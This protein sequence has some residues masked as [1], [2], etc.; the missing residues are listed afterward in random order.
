MQKH[1]VAF[2]ALGSSFAPQLPTLK[3]CEVA[4]VTLQFSFGRSDSATFLSVSRLRAVSLFSVVRRAK[5]ETR[6]RPRAWL[7]VRDGRGTKKESLSFF[8]SGCRP[9][10]ARL[11]V[12]PLP[13]ACIALRLNLKKKRDCSQSRASVTWIA[14]KALP[15]ITAFIQENFDRTSK[16]CE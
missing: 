8:F 9:R 12:S 14:R 16:K 11:A 3:C 4:A 10:F 1:C 13:R 2:E 7:M 6:K 5:C 15:Q